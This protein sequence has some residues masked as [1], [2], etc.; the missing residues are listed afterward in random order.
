MLIQCIIC[1]R[2]LM[3]KLLTLNEAAERLG[4]CRR[5]LGELKS[6]GAFPIVRL[7]KKAIRVHPDDL[8]A[9]AQKMRVGGEQ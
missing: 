1:F 4:I 8:E 9:F 3:K 5:Y 7:G 2:M 6:K